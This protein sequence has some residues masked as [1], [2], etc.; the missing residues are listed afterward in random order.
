[1]KNIKKEKLLYISAGIVVAIICLI[2]CLI[3][4]SNTKEEN[5]IFS[6]ENNTLYYSES[7]NNTPIE[8]DEIYVHVAGEVKNPGVVKVNAGD[9]VKDVV[10]MAGGFS[11]EA[12]INKVNLAYIVSDGQKIVIPNINTSNNNE[13]DNENYYS[14]DSGESFIV[15]SNNGNSKININVA[16]QTELETLD[17]I[18]PSMATKIIAYRQANG[19]FKTIEDIKNVS[20]IGESKFKSI[21]SFICVK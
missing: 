4:E 6:D 21:E 16:S 17:G 18:G 7:S 12:D 13:Q 3:I 2:V 11:D 10:E 8:N 5:Y 20:G 15:E 1:M 19:K 14:D 9:R